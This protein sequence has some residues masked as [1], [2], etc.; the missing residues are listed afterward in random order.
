MGSI[1][2]QGINNTIITYIGVIIG[3]VNILIIQP[4]MLLPEELGL[5]RILT[6]TS[7]IF[8]TLFPLGLNRVMIKYFPKFR[9]KD[10]G[11]HGFPFLVMLTALASYLVLGL[12]FYFLKDF[13]FEKYEKSPLFIEYFTYIFPLSL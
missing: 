13:W 10:S 3:F 11:N 9:D 1:R 7:I 5:T 6:S 12:V 8:G 4:R 2:K